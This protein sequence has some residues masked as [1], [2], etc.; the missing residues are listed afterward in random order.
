[1]T[2]ASYITSLIL[3]SLRCEL[4]VTLPTTQVY[5]TDEGYAFPG[6]TKDLSS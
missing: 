1:M 3:S 5:F 6:L 2:L 4:G